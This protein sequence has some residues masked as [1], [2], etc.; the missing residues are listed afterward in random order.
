M[1]ENNYGLATCLLYDIA[2][3]AE[4]A[5]T[6][7]QHSSLDDPDAAEALAVMLVDDL[8]RIGWL[9]DRASHLMGSLQV[10]GDADAWMLPP[11]YRTIGQEEAVEADK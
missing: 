1:D 10:V 6:I 9:A 3:I 4:R 2:L 7:F 11:I 5:K 8:K